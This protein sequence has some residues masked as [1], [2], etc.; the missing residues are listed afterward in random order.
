MM[1]NRMRDLDQLE[2]QDPGER[3]RRIGIFLTAAIAVVGVVFAIVVAISKV[4]EPRESEHDPLDQLDRIASRALPAPVDAAAALAPKK[5]DTTK[6]TFER[7]LT[8]HEERP[9]VIAALE[10]AAREEQ[11]LAHGDSPSQPSTTAPTRPGEPK[12]AL[13]PAARVPQ[14]AALKNDE[15][16]D[17]E[18]EPEPEPEPARQERVPN[19]MPAGMAASAANHKVVQSARHDK[20]VAEALPKRSTQPRARM[21]EEGEF[22]LQVISYDTQAA[23]QAFAN[24]LR[25]KGHEAFVVTGEVDGRGRYYRVR[26]GPFKTKP[27]AEAYRHTFE[28]QERMNTIVVKRVSTD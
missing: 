10:A 7:D 8:E 25:A 26:I 22:T 18:P 17:D 21:G 23:A 6:L 9:E 15:A 16:D 12:P 13:P 14:A 2:E 20:L 5:I 11:S 4:T 28:A 27:Q 24:G 3:G 19:A 1:E